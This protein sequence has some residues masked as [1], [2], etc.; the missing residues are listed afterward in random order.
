LTWERGCFYKAA[1]ETATPLA[2]L[3]LLHWNVGR[4]GREIGSRRCS[5]VNA[6]CLK[7]EDRKRNVDGEVLADLLSGKSNEASVC[8]VYK[9]HR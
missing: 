6:C 4:G 7:T 1:I 9:S 8:C 3:L 2:A 5:V